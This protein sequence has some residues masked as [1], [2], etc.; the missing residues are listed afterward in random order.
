MNSG[1][2]WEDYKKLPVKRFPFE[3]DSVNLYH[4]PISCTLSTPSS[5]MSSGCVCRMFSRLAIILL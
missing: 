4:H 3:F 5:N 2:T 1:F